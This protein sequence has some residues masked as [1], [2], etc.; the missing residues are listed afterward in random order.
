MISVGVLV[1][2]TTRPRPWKHISALE[3]HSIH[4]EDNKKNKKPLEEYFEKHRAPNL[5]VNSEEFWNGWEPE[6]SD[7]TMDHPAFHLS[8][9][10]H[11]L[12]ISSLT[13]F[14]HS[15]GR[16]KILIYTNPPVESACLL[17]QLAAVISTGEEG[18]SGVST[19]RINVLGVIGL[20]DLARIEK[21]NA[22]SNGWI[23]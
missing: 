15:L 3:R 7:A 11:I 22:Q 8:H 4:L 23:A 20:M 1:A 9:V 13:L 10:L 18:A 19:R 5:H 17:A 21:E 2:N 16:R 6:L 12:G 14:K